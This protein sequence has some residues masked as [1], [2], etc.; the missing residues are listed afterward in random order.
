MGTV[1][2][3][4][5]GISLFTP[6]PC[7]SLFQ[8][9]SELDNNT[10]PSTRP[11][12]SEDR[13]ISFEQGTNDTMGESEDDDIG[14]EELMCNENIDV[15][16]KESDDSDD[17]EL[18]NRVFPQQRFSPVPFTTRRSQT[19][20][21]G[22]I[23][24]SPIEFPPKRAVT[25]NIYEHMISKS[26]SRELSDIDSSSKPPSKM[27]DFGF[28]APKS[29]PH[30]SKSMDKTESTRPFSGQFVRPKQP[31]AKSHSP[32]LTVSGHFQ[33][34]GSVFRPS[35]PSSNSIGNSK[36]TPTGCES[37]KAAMSSSD[38]LHS[39]FSQPAQFPSHFTKFSPSVSASSTS[40]TTSNAAIGLQSKSPVAAYKGSGHGGLALS[41]SQNLKVMDTTTIPRVPSLGQKEPNHTNS[42]SLTSRPLA[43]VEVPSTAGSITSQMTR[44]GASVSSSL[45]PLTVSVATHSAAPFHQAI[46]S[47]PTL[48]PG[49]KGLHLKPIA[50]LLSP[51]LMA[52]SPSGEKTSA[53]VLLVKKPAPLPGPVHGQ[54]TGKRNMVVDVAQAF[55]SHGGAG[56]YNV[57]P[58]ALNT[59]HTVVSQLLQSPTKPR[60]GSPR[61]THGLNTGVSTRPSPLSPRLTTANISQLSPKGGIFFSY[62]QTDKAAAPSTSC[63][64][65]RGVS[66]TVTPSSHRQPQPTRPQQE[67]VA[68]HPID[69]QATQC[70]PCS[71]EGGDTGGL[72][73]QT[74][75]KPILKRYIADGMEE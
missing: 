36:L 60:Q 17:E 61:P 47:T 28:R 27:V 30:S 37:S 23:R 59:N 46:K 4:H 58:T 5:I 54:T 68:P 16:D 55:P 42:G 40:N 70:L 38:V 71:G 11:P 56:Y 73:T 74:N 8:M 50:P 67:Q 34:T 13:H 53:R 35:Q 64:S 14:S 21:I 19:P 10:A 72:M 57:S 26:R 22:K 6:K 1:V 29:L 66:N 62:P 65:P 44:S 49:A 41:A 52:T 12:V 3:G 24:Y 39:S 43:V 33:P 31:L 2:I 18:S 75:P 25:P 69:A 20:D 63:N 15:N 7:S 51:P 48:S 32:G 45:A 9:C